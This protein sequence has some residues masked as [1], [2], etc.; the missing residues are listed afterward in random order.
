[1]IF[2]PLTVSAGRA[3]SGM[4]EAIAFSV[5]INAMGYWNDRLAG[6]GIDIQRDRRFDEPVLEFRDPHGL[7]PELVG[8]TSVPS[9]VPWIESPV[10]P[11]QGIL[12]FHSATARLNSLDETYKRLTGIINGLD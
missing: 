2:C 6:M 1:M 5:P 8:V 11:S 10:G 4:L 9:R 7:F 12:V 3:G